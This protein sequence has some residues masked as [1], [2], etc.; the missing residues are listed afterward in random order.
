MLKLLGKPVDASQTPQEQ[1]RMLAGLL[2][3]TRE[4]IQILLD[5]YQRSIFGPY[6]VD[7]EQAQRA[8]WLLWR[9]VLPVWLR[10]KL[11]LS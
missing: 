7:L 8:H 6:L 10:R 11:H 2:P 3:Q 1:A 9:I 5:Q 4:P